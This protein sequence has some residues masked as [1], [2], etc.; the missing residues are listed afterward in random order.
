MTK[1]GFIKS[2]LNRTVERMGRMDQYHKLPIDYV[3]RGL[4]ELRQG[5]IKTSSLEQCSEDME[6]AITPVLTFLEKG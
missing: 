4:L 2:E 3:R 6:S 1:T 5:M